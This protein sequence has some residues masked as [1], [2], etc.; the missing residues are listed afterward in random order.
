MGTSDDALAK[1]LV[2]SEAK[3]QLSQT[4]DPMVGRCLTCGEYRGRSEVYQVERDEACVYACVACGA[5]ID[6]SL[7][8]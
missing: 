3:R 6:E 4:V 8:F 5:T 1:A 7:S 2:R